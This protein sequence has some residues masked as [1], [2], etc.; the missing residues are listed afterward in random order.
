M[1]RIIMKNGEFI[2][3][4]QPHLFSQVKNFDFLKD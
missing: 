3:F 1:K 2:I 4:A